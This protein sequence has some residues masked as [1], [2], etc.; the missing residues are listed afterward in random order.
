L[1]FTQDGISYIGTDGRDSLVLTT[2]VGSWEFPTGG[3]AFIEALGEDDQVTFNGNAAE[4]TLVGGDGND[5]TLLN[6][7]GVTGQL[8]ASSINGNAGDDQTLWLN[9]TNSSIYG[10][11]GDDF[12]QARAQAGGTTTNA[13]EVNGNKGNDDISLTGSVTFTN[14]YGSQDDDDIEIHSNGQQVF[15]SSF[16]GNK[17][18]DCLIIDIDAGGNNTVYGG[19]DDDVINARASATD[20]SLLLSGDKGNDVIFGSA[21]SAGDQTIDGGEDRDILVYQGNTNTTMIGGEGPDVFRI[22][23][24][25][26]D[27]GA[28]QGDASA[29]FIDD[30]DTTEDNIEINVDF[31]N[32]FRGFPVYFDARG[33]S[34]PQVAPYTNFFGPTNGVPGCA[35]GESGIEVPVAYNW[36]AGTFTRTTQTFTGSSPSTALITNTFTFYTSVRQGLGNLLA[37]NYFNQA[38]GGITVGVTFNI[39]EAASLSGHLTDG[40]LFKAANFGQVEANVVAKAA[41]F[42]WTR[43]FTSGGFPITIPFAPSNGQSTTSFLNGANSLN[44]VMN[45][46][47]FTQDSRKLYAF[48]NIHLTSR[49]DNGAFLATS[50]LEYNVRTLAQ[51]ATNNVNGSDIFL[52]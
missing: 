13:S 22:N 25:A 23:A 39:T 45:A 32:I 17:G 51:F 28:D 24:L 47:A 50:R 40:M 7:G 34:T 15:D 11:Q 19:A 16:Q 44:Q 8:A 31:F 20:G 42:N 3:P 35:D 6:G 9:I 46:L 37:A 2:G 18:D 36:H 43:Q 21:F 38:G 33:A 30:F 49:T 14:V 10:G 5:V 12:L 48:T 52:V 29:P 1:A 27:D 4:V 41:L 26:A